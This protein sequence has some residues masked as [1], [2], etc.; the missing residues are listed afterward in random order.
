[1]PAPGDVVKNGQTDVYGKDRYE[2]DMHASVFCILACLQTA[3][4]RRDIFV[5]PSWRYA[6]PRANLLSG[7]EWEAVKPI[8]ICRALE[9]HTRLT[10]E[11][12]KQRRYLGDLLE[13]LIEAN[14][15]KL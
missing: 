7:A 6:D 9:L 10:I 1:M 15:P 4:K 8:I 11:A 5:S 14:V 2:F 12:A 13:E 3:L